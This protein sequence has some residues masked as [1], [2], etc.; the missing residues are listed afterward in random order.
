MISQII[1]APAAN[2]LW[3]STLFA[4]VAFILALV[5]RKN[6]AHTRYWL[7]LSASVK[8]LLPFSLLIDLGNYLSPRVPA[9]AQS[10]FTVV[11]KIGQ[12]FPPI[13]PA[14]A[15]SS[16]RL[17]AVVLHMLPTLL[18]VVWLIGV[19]SVLFYWGLRWRKL[20]ASIRGNS[21]VK[22]GQEF[23]MLR[24]LE[25]GHGISNPIELIISESSLEPGIAGI[26][27]PQLLLPAGIAERL[28]DEQLLA[29]LAHELCHVRRRDNLAAAVH[30]LVE[31]LFWFHPLVWWIGA[32]L[33]D[34]RER[35]CDE[36]V[37]RQGSDR[38]VY[39]ESILK[40]CEFYLESPLFCAAGVT[41]SNLKKRIEAI[42]IDRITRKLAWGKKLLL[43]T[44]GTLA[45]V[46]PVV[47]GALNPARGN[48]QEMIVS[49][50]APIGA[51]GVAGSAPTLDLVSIKPSTA[52][53]PLFFVDTKQGIISFTGFTLKDLIK[54]SYALHDSQIVGGPDW[55]SSER[56]DIRAMGP[57]G[58]AMNFMQVQAGVQKLLAH[59]FA[60]VLHRDIRELSV[61]AMVVGKDGPKLEE[62]HSDN[63]AVR[64][65]RML[66]NTPGHI[67]AQQVGMV[68][69]ADVLSSSS[70]SL[71]ID[72]TGLKGIYNFT[73]EWP[74][75]S[76]DV[77][78]EISTALPDQLGLELNKQT[79]PVSVLVVDRAEEGV[80]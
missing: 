24:R 49:G 53:Q 44:M 67:Q 36:E 9:F 27:R 77:P 31:A 47:I 79:A 78:A 1:A 20:T 7:W 66:M 65:S 57:S 48:A 12:P 25:L 46:G 15:A 63:S 32:R 30:M 13:E 26:F 42:M 40:V 17:F 71:V 58:N 37:L 4:G 33:V 72:K 80:K 68:A 59:H 39:A 5:L 75:P 14:Y 23:E 6:Q 34:E 62:I 38:Q 18:I 19:F 51:M 21:P 74:M 54:Y 11:Q 8:F 10:E 60:L 55:I 64:K 56:F 70:N 2:H 61:Y 41:G 50:P 3:Q 35:A 28:T 29:V 69:L 16:T 73:L 52:T 76:S 45:I 22:A 43:A